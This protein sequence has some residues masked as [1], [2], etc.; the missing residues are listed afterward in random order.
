[1]HALHAHKPRKT[2]LKHNYN[3]H[4]IN[5]NHLYPRSQKPRETT[6]SRCPVTSTATYNST[7]QFSISSKVSNMYEAPY[8]E[9]TE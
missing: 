1:M 9:K 2:I 6:E 4:K 8:S 3:N 5:H 7:I